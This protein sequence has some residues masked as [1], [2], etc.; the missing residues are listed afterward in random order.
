MDTYEGFSDWNDV[1]KEFFDYNWSDNV[2]VRMEKALAAIPEPEEVIYAEYHQESYEGSALV[3]FRN[4]DKFYWNQ[5]SH[6]SCYGLEGQ[7]SPEEYD[8]D[9]F[10]KVLDRKLEGNYFYR[11]ETEEVLRYIREKV[12][13]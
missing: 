10:I 9:T 11:P 1:A 3:V 8:R 2:D 4:G 12:I 5:G 7:W 6:C 13:A